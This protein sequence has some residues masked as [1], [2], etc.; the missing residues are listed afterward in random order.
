MDEIKIEKGIDI[1]TYR[2]GHLKRRCRYSETLLKCNIGDSFLIPDKKE[3]NDKARSSVSHMAARRGWKI[4][5]RFAGKCPKTGEYKRRVW[6]I[7]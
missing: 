2:L 1:K 5:T 7:E 3:D 6:R 4:A